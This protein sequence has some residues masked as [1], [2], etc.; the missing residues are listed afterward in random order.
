M[1]YS[2]Y[3]I[4]PVPQPRMVRS[5]KWAKRPRVLRYFAFRDECKLKRVELPENYH[6][7]FVM[8]MPKS[9]SAKKCEQMNGLPHRNKPDKDNLEKALL[10][11]IYRDDSQVWDG[12]VTKIWGY[13]GRIYITGIGK[14]L[15]P[16]VY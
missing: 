7:V 5:D 2:V 6:V 16:G 12:R 11:A 14:P 13:E 9:W 3:R 10:D 15:L 1:S 8:P 4:T